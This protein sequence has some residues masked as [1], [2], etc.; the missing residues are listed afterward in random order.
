VIN[1]IRLE[2]KKESS[3]LSWAIKRSNLP[4]KV[5]IFLEE[6]QKP[7]VAPGD[8]VRTGQKIAEPLLP[9]SVALHAS[10]SGE[11]K[12][13]SEFPHP[14]GS[15]ARAIEIISDGRDEKAPSV[16]AERLGWEKLS[17]QELR[18]IFRDSG[19]V[20]LNMKMQ[21]VHSVI[22]GEFKTLILNGCES[23][24]YLTSDH[25]LM[26]SHP[27][28]TLKGAE[29]LRKACGAARVV[30]TLEENKREIME[31]FKSK[32]FFLKWKHFEVKEFPSFYPQGSAEILHQE[33]IADGP[34]CLLNVATAFSAYEAVVFQK[35]VYERAVTIGG[36]CVIEPKNFWVRVGTDIETLIKNAKGF[37]REPKKLLMGGPMT[38]HAQTSWEIPILKGTQAVLGLPEEVVKRGEPEACIRC[39]RCIE[40]CPTGISPVMITLAAE[41]EFWEMSEDYGVKLCIECGNCA[42]VCPAKRP[43]MEWIRAAKESL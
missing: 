4:A 43:M 38:G 8:K 27:V 18:E 9:E 19:L 32:I 34:S 2:G 13:I 39:G 26:M 40:A 7:C 30:I 41:R 17:S 29:I 10:L 24:P 28:E 1:G 20:D 3:L 42:Y 21:S 5:R 14:T 15:S 37:L 11:V 22:L 12:M 31:L 25:A 6:G 23:E 16:G 35:P 36:E 33:F